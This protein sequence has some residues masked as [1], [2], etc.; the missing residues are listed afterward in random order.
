MIAIIN[1]V[2]EI[3]QKLLAKSET[4]ADRNV[5]RIYHELNEMG[6]Q[7]KNPVGRK[8]HETD[9]DLEANLSGPLQGQLTVT[10]VLK[11]VIYKK[12]ANGG[13]EL[14]QKGIVI[15]EGK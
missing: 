7:V 10:R 12:A 15:V 13:M 3:E 14:M 2:F 11:P 1:Q 4:V 8:Y 6:Y 9:T 5:K